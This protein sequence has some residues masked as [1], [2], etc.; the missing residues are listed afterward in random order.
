MCGRC[1]RRADKQQIS[2]CMRVNAAIELEEKLEYEAASQTPKLK[3]ERAAISR[4]ARPVE[5]SSPSEAAYAAVRPPS[6]GI[7][8]PLMNDASSLAR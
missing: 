3:A 6:M 5:R 7:A 1:G 4:G 2:E 8:A